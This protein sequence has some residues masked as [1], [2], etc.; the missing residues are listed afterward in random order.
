MR[1]LRFSHIRFFYNCLLYLLFPWVM[2]LLYGKTYNRP[3]FG[4]RWVEH[5]GFGQSA[6]LDKSPIWLH[7]ASVGEIMAAKPLLKKLN[8]Q[9]P[10]TALLVTTTTSTGQLSLKSLHINCTHQF[11]PL[12]Y[13]DAVAR[14]LNKNKP[15]MLLLLETELWPNW[16]H[17]CA[18]RKIPVL[19]IN[20]R[21]SQRS[22]RRYM[23]IRALFQSMTQSIHAFCCQTKQDA[24]RFAKLGIDTHKLS[25][26]GSLKFEQILSEERQHQGQN[27]RNNL[28]KQRLAWIAGSTHDGEEKALLKVHKKLCIRYKSP[29]L[30]LVPRHVERTDELATLCKTY[31]LKVTLRSQEPV[32]L[33]DTDVYLC[34][35]TGELNMLY[36]ACD[37]A[38]IGGSLIP[39]G[40]HNPLEAAAMSLPILFGVHVFN[41]EKIYQQLEYN[42]AA[43]RCDNLASLQTEL[44]SLFDSHSKRLRMGAC[45]QRLITE[46]QGALQQVMQTLS[47]EMG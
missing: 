32:P 47:P 26:T 41:F 3:S 44:I 45:G 1:T 16:I 29:L 12:D 42:Q 36:A 2:W 34:D 43:I 37:V 24:R 39:R 11:A 30:F 13:P 15:K 28:G 7:A 6:T 25:I 14:F 18:K 20:A 19:L 8:E 21:L 27:L 22:F 5:F 4:R 10:D 46:N 35:T 17:G 9:Y 38:F 23:R 33:P 31:D 40:G